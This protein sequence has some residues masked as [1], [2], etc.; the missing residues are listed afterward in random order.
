MTEAAKPCLI[1]NGL[2]A[3]AEDRNQHAELVCVQLFYSSCCSRNH[4]CVLRGHIGCSYDCGQQEHQVPTVLPAGEAYYNQPQTAHYVC[5]KPATGLFEYI[6][7]HLV[8]RFQR[9]DHASIARLQSLQQQPGQTYL[10]Y[11]DTALALITP[12]PR[13]MLQ[14]FQIRLQL[15]SLQRHCLTAYATPSGEAH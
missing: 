13:D 9:V 15:A 11:L 5:S 14:P 4:G 3:C 7:A 2:R 1:T 8:A 6:L 10:Q 12:L